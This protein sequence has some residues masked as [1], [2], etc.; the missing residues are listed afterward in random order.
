MSSNREEVLNR[1]IAAYVDNTQAGK[2]SAAGVNAIVTEMM[3]AKPEDRVSIMDEF[4]D[5]CR[6]VMNV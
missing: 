5:K 4:E 6:G 2:T 1:M 3:N